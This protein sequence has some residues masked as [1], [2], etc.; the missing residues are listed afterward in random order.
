[1]VELRNADALLSNEIQ[2][3]SQILLISLQWPIEGY[4]I[5]FIENLALGFSSYT[6]ET[7]H[8]KAPRLDAM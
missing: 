4:C 3:D 5:T 7:S 1:M 8:F 6:P 2:V